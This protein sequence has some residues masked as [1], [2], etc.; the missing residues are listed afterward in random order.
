MKCFTVGS[1]RKDVKLHLECT[2]RKIPSPHK[3]SLEKIQKTSPS[4]KF[5]NTLIGQWYKLTGVRTALPQT[6]VIIIFVLS[7]ILYSCILYQAFKDN[8]T[9]CKIQKENKF[10]I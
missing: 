7:S 8:G 1:F 5:V 4:G 2:K 3:E 10:I 6:V 9:T